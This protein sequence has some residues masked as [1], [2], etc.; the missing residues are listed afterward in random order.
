MAPRSMLLPRA[1]RCMLLLVLVLNMSL[2]ALAASP[3]PSMASTSK[4]VRTTGPADPTSPVLAMQAPAKEPESALDH[5][6]KQLRLIED[7]EESL[8]NGLNN[9]DAELSRSQRPRR[10]IT[11]ARIRSDIQGLRENLQLLARNLNM[12]FSEL[13]TVEKD[14]E[15]KAKQLNEVLRQQQADEQAHE[16][17]AQGAEAIDY[18]SGR[19][20]NLTH[21]ELSAKERQHLEKVENDADPAVLHYDFS[22]LGQIALLFGVSA[23][24]GIVTS[25][26]NLPPTIGYLVG[27]AVVGPSG[28]GLVH[29]FKEVETISLFGTIFLL[30]AHGAEYSVQRAD[31]VLKRYLV[32]GAL[33]VAATMVC[34][35]LVGTSLG[36]APSLSEGLI[37][38]AGV[39]FTSTAPLAEYVRTQSLRHTVFG[40]LV[41]AIVAVQD[42]LMSFALATPE[43]FTHH[44]SAGLVSIAVL[45]TLFA[46]GIVVGLTIVLH[47]RVV[48]PLLAFLASME[49]VHHSPLVLLG[50]VS[51][52]LF[53]AL[54]T[55]TLGL[56]LESGAF[57]AGLAFMGQT[58]LK[59]TLTSIRV[60]DNLFGSMF[61][62]C[63]GM[64]LNP[65]YLVRNCLQ[66][67][68][69]MLC[70]VVIKITLL[71][72]L[73]TFFR[74]PI[75]RA[76]KAALS[77]CQ[78]GEVAL[79]FMIKAQAT[80]L[81]S[82][83]VYLQFLAATSVFLGLSPF[84]HKSLQG[85]STFHFAS[86]VSRGK[87][88]ADDDMLPTSHANKFT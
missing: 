47:V 37:L 6:E 12:T 26:I 82:R 4:V 44:G 15:E 73:M 51:V 55:E 39:C 41:T 29:H 85:Q 17:E 81:I 7:L 38:G 30:F 65:V 52:C 31:E 34:M 13:D 2:L 19:L 56:S 32:A 57:F 27:G 71:L 42:V 9:I 62:A 1:Q 40:R 5:L 43:W 72:G 3:A 78:V 66:V 77:L 21:S 50:I 23:L 68:S 48:P 16:I 53:M 54:F 36:W 46:Y 49:Q 64:I 11:Q 74:I 22:L 67:L 25:W 45:K 28:L 33:Y 86:V 75:L 69:M 10:D 61:F 76:M 83:P 14:T 63:I 58:N 35:A 79:I 8:L 18:E 70:I 80:Q 87:S 88:A 59:V 84:L 24:G 20:K 60:L